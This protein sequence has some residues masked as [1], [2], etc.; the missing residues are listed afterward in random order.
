M[1][2]VR[3]LVERWVAEAGAQAQDDD[4]TTVLMWVALGGDVEMARLLLDKGADIHAQN[5]SGRTVLMYGARGGDV[6]VV[7]F[8]LDK[9]TDLNAQDAS[10]QSALMYAAW[11]GDA[12]GGSAFA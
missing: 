4:G 1:G 7:R 12:G 6:E 5:N 11:G 9:G 8:L 2:V 3:I 10:D